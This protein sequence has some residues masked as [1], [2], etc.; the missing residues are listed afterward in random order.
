MVLCKISDG[1]LNHPSSDII[2]KT[3]M[4]TRVMVKAMV[5]TDHRI[6]SKKAVIER[7]I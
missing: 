2:N 7:V 1:S 3:K 4:P 5:T 6:N